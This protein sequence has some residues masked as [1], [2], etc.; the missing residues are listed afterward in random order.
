[1]RKLEQE[2]VVKA[3]GSEEKCVADSSLPGSSLGFTH[4]CAGRARPDQ[5]IVV[6]LGS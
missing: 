6:D 2:Q 5:I 1:M 4:C 3:R